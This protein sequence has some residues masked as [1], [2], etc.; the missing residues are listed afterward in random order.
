MV[1]NGSRSMLGVIQLF[2]LSPP[3]LVQPLCITITIQCRL[4]ASG[5]EVHIGH[6]HLRARYYT[7]SRSPN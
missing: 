7:S 6:Y 3:R 5:R 1:E 4:S 2:R